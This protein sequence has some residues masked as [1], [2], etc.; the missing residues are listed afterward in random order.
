MSD[1]FYAA[2]E[3]WPFGYSFM[4]M[5]IIVEAMTPK[6]LGPRTSDLGH[7]IYLGSGTVA[8]LGR[9]EIAA[10]DLGICAIALPKWNDHD[11]RLQA[12][13]AA[14]F[15]VKRAKHPLIEQALAELRAYADGSCLTFNVALD[16]RHLPTFTERVLLTLLLVPAGQL[17]TYGQ[18]AAKAGSP[19]ASRAVGGAV[20]RNPIPVI[21]PCHRVV[22]S[23]GIGGFGLGLPCKRVL[24]AMEGVHLV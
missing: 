21:V 6:D 4:T 9:I 23:N 11:L 3:M 13:E 20:G 16:L 10:T 17:L 24:L 15:Q 12:W 22:A 5:D 14:G 1:V 8:Q 7:K 2:S 18:L 19:K